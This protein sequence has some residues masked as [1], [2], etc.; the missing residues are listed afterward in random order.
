MKLNFTSI[1]FKIA[2]L[3][4]FLITGIIVVGLLGGI[5]LYKQNI[6][7][8]EI[9]A[10][11]QPAVDAATGSKIAII[12]MGKAQG[13]LIGADEAEDIR[14]AAIYAIRASAAVDEY[15]Q[16]MA[17]IL[18][19]NQDVSRLSELLS[20]IKP[21]R[22]KII[23]YGRKNQDTQALMLAKEMNSKILEIQ[24]LADALLF[25][26]RQSM[27][28]AMDE[29]Q[30]AGERVLLIKAALIL[31]GVLISIIASIIFMRSMIKPLGILEHSMDAMAHGDLALTVTSSSHDE[32]GR[33]TASMQKMISGLHLLV[34]NISEKAGLVAND[35]IKVANSSDSIQSVSQ[36]FKTLVVEIKREDEVILSASNESLQQ[37]AAVAENSRISSSEALAANQ[38]I[39]ETAAN[40]ESFK[41]H[42]VETVK[43]TQDLEKSAET[44]ASIVTTI[45]SISE[46]TNLLALNAAIEAAR[47]GE[48]GRGFSV[49]ADEVR[50]LAQRT[51]DATSE[52][53]KLISMI[54]EKV[55]L[56]IKLLEKTSNEAVEN[57]ARLHSVAGQVDHSSELV[58]GM[59][60]NLQAIEELMNT[61]VQ[62]LSTMNKEV[63]S[64]I[65]LSDET[66]K[67]SSLLDQLSIDLNSAAENLNQNI[68]QFKL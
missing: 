31:L 9:I 8:R 11:A 56:S 57:I 23:G 27:S 42:M 3:S 10:T 53:E 40:F 39:K 47:A 38:Q 29:Y 25:E 36:R 46:Q 54:N 43:T 52:I 45:R 5:S 35:A 67:Q 21:Q 55:G 30:Q 16:N 66:N 6:E 34:N 1:K 19:D 4:G 14:A 12:E 63:D 60:S 58:T 44:I 62:S 61:Q 41:E 32:I 15:I 59:S 24:E 26:Q 20:Q 18:P 64:M 33:T 2:A 50:V 65:Q 68:A 51:E 22:L 17:T 13:E 49:V 7:I 48:Q 28:L 37:L